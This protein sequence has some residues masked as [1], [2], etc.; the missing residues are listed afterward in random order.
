M[1]IRLPGPAFPRPAGLLATALGL[2]LLCGGCN[3]EVGTVELPK[4]KDRSEILPGFDPN[5]TSPYQ[6]GATKKSSEVEEKVK[7]L[8]PRL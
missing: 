6:K 3:S 7:P 4:V 8:N 1:S 2:S 5:A